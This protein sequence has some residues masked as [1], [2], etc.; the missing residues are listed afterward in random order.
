MLP[1]RPLGLAHA[2]LAQLDRAQDYESWGRPFESARARFL[3]LQ[4][5]VPTAKPWARLSLP[6]LPEGNFRFR[7]STALVR[8]Y[9]MIFSRYGN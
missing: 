8:E 4:R 1:T 6:T 9:T 5:H 2:P 7:G 3:C